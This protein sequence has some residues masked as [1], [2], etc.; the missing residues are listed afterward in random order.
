MNGFVTPLNDLN[1]EELYNL[2]KSE[3]EGFLFKVEVLNGDDEIEYTKENI[4][5][6]NNI[7][8]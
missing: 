2:Q 7:K 1:F 6:F 3:V 5:K 4:Q 8:L